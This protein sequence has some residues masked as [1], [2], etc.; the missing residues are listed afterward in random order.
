MAIEVRIPT[1]L[2]TYTGGEKAVERRGRHAG[3]AH[4]RPREQ[5][6]RASR[7]GC[8]EK[9]A[10][11]L[12]RFVNV[13]VNDEDVRF[14]G[15]LETARQR[16][17]QRRRAARP[18][19]AA[20]LPT[21]LRLLLDSVG[22]TPLVGLPRLSPT[23]RRPA[24]GQARGPQPDRLDQG[25]AGAADGRGGRE[26]R[27]GSGPGCTILEP[28][29][30]NTGIS[31]AMAA[32]LKG[33]RTRLR[34]AGEHLGGAAPAAADVG[35]RDHLLAGRGRLERGGPGRQAGRRGAPRLGDALPV[36]QPGERA[37]ALRRAP[38]PRSSPTCRRSPT[39]SA[40]LGTTGT[41]MGVGPLLPR[42]QAGGRDRRRRAPLRRAG[43]RPAQPR[44]GLRP[45]A[46]RRVADR[47]PVLGRPARRRTPGARAARA[48]RASSPASRPARSCTPRSAQAAEGG[49]GRRAAPTSRSSSATAAG[50]T[51]PPA[52]T[53]APSTRPRSASRAS[54]GPERCRRDADGTR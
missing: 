25:P 37:R 52:P 45:R 2:R 34:D 26:G 8:V 6:P 46:V 50:S 38:A 35:R 44:R 16:R 53:R 42:A 3:R 29:S 39:S 28:T 9:D 21:A 5:P 49:Q 32:K 51:C 22:G 54:S 47:R 36:R 10:G 13:Y 14:L 4:R 31:L 11:D 12:R 20:E 24:V 1:I 18:S 30:G 15:G 33:Y 41:L 19:P 27:A 40:G 48:T 23:R 7:S 17:R 43:L